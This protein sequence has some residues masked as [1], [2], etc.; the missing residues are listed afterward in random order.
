MYSTNTF[1]FSLPP[2]FLLSQRFFV[3]H[4][5]GGP[6]LR[7]DGRDLLHQTGPDVLRVVRHRL[8]RHLLGKQKHRVFHVSFS[9]KTTPYEIDD[10][11]IF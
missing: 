6:G 1:E 5:S 7:K 2:S 9:K 11:D 3:A 4:N 10:F 8:W